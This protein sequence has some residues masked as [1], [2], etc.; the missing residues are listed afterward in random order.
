MAR[1]GARGELNGRRAGHTRPPLVPVRRAATSRPQGFSAGGKIPDVDA[2]TRGRAERFVRRYGETWEAWDIDGFVKLF[3]EAVS[4]V[5]HPDE[6]VE[7][8]TA[9]RTYVEGERK[10]QGDVRVRM[11]RPLVEGDRVMAEFWVTAEEDA[12]IAGC[13]IAHLDPQGVCIAF[14]EYW[15]D[16]DGRREAFE[17]WGT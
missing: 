7:G 5:A 15:F 9:L 16:L 3:G 17:G 4:Y 10:A 2:G 12:S 1:A 11:G 14:R 6:I 13:L 8:S